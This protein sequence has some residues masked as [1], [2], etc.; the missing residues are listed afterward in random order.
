MVYHEAID[1]TP[2]SLTDHFKN[3]LWAF[4]CQ[5]Y[6]RV[7]TTEKLSGRLVL[8]MYLVPC[9]VTVPI[10][11]FWHCIITS[12]AMNLQMSWNFFFV[13]VT[14]MEYIYLIFNTNRFYEGFGWNKNEI[15]LLINNLIFLYVY[16]PKKSVFFIFVF[17]TLLKY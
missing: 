9:I 15:I 13:I 17:T 11:I 14:P 5:K 1:F 2:S 10:F 8:K 12:E 7:R 6:S 16:N 4:F 3:R